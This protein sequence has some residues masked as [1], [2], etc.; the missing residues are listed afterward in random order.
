MNKIQKL[1]SNDL[2][3]LEI[4]PLPDQ[5]LHKLLIIATKSK[6]EKEKKE[7][8]KKIVLHILPIIINRCKKYFPEDYLIENTDFINEVVMVILDRAF[9]NFRID[10]QEENRCS[11]FFK[12]IQYYILLAYK[13]L[14]RKQF[15]THEVNFKEFL[16]PK[17]DQEYYRQIKSLTDNLETYSLNYDLYDY[18][19]DDD[20]IYSSDDLIEDWIIN[21]SIDKSAF[22]QYELTEQ[23]KEIEKKE[24]LQLLNKEVFARCSLLD[25][26]IINATGINSFPY[27]FSSSDLEYLC[28][29]SKKKIN[30]LKKQ[31]IKKVKEIT[32]FHLVKLLTKGREYYENTT[33]CSI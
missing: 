30:S 2:K 28:K 16:N 31:T 21:K 10:E 6:D 13:N 32:Q 15:G 33:N 1:L 26:I 12:M 8:R 5:E 29:V 7:A 3:K 17:A 22:Y 9:D 20:K 19:Y 27:A 11:L 23:E 24:Y 25:N 14:K 4:K 18:N